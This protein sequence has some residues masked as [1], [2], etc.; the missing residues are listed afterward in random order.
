MSTISVPP[1]VNVEEDCQELNQAFRGLGCDAKKVIAILGHRTQVQR[2][3][4]ADTYYQQFGEDLHERLKSELHGHFEKA[5]LLWMMDATKRDTQL[6]I[7]SAKG[8]GANDT[9]FLGILCSRTPSQI[10]C[11]KQTYF[12][13][14]SKSLES[15]IEGETTGDYRKLLLALVRGDRSESVNVD[16]QLAETDAHELYRA[17]ASRLGANEDTFIHVLTS[18]SAVQLSTTLQFYLR[19]FGHD[20]EK[21]IKKETAGNF[22]TALLTVMECTCYPAQFFAKELYQSMKGLG[23]DDYT[24]IRVVVTRAE[25]DMQY[26]KTEFS[27]IYK[28]TLE[29]MISGDTSGNYRLFLL[30]LVGGE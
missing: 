5:M 9:A 28:K 14:Y 17:G 15:H 7:E 2:L 8:I 29:Q 4:I 1:I 27:S 30:T 25:T 3:A 11:I 23:T 6:L 13:T 10:L 18:R 22:Q 24:L 12:K 21:V 16:Q 26:I 20:L 19:T